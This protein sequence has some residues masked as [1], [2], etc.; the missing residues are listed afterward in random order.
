MKFNK[1]LWEAHVK[2]ELMDIRRSL[3]TFYVA[4][5]GGTRGRANAVP[6]THTATYRQKDRHG[7][8][9]SYAHDNR[10]ILI[11]TRLLFVINVDE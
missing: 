9:V 11:N 3:T 7:I 6:L 1:E 5:L 10:R 4:M 8:M 2:G